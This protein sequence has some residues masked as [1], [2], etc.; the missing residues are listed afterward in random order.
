MEESFDQGAIEKEVKR[1]FIK[2]SVL[3]HQLMHIKNIF[4]FID[5]SKLK[6]LTPKEN[7]KLEGK[8]DEKEVSH[9]L[10]ITR[11]NMAPGT[12]GFTG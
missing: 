9:C 4:K 7:K 8:I 11:N 3:K 5:K 6:T 12:S 2:V 1:F 10:K